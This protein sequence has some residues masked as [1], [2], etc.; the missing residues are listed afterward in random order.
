MRAFIS[1][2]LPEEIKKEIVKIQNKLPEFIGKK[3]EKQNLHLTLKFLGEVGEEEL[4][5]I[6]KKL[7][8]FIY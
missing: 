7:N 6:K 4:E 3:T 1:L 5:K 2:E 8:I